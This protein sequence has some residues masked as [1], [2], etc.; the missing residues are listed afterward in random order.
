MN[1]K[2]YKSYLQGIEDYKNSS[3]P[4]ER[5]PAKQN[6]YQLGYAEAIASELEVGET[7]IFFLEIQR[8]YNFGIRSRRFKVKAKVTHKVV[9][10]LWTVNDIQLI[11][12]IKDAEWLDYFN[13]E[14]ELCKGIKII[15]TNQLLGKIK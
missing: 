1:T 3:S 8:K 13:E 5:T 14:L 4:K 9:R 15:H 11:K 7:I 6:Y 10:G 2:E 12:P